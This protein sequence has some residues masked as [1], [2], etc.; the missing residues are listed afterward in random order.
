MKNKTHHVRPQKKKGV[1]LWERRIF[2]SWLRFTRRHRHS[3]RLPFF[4]FLLF[5]LDGFV[6]VVPS[7]LCMVACVTISPARWFLFAILFP[8]GAT[9][10]NA[11]TYLLGTLIPQ[12][13]LMSVIEFFHL[14]AFWEEAMKAVH[15]YGNWAGFVGAIM[16]LPTQMITAIIGLADVQVNA[17]AAIRELSIF[18]ALACV[19][20][21][22]FLKS[23]LVA[24][25]VVKGWSKI[26]VKIVESQRRSDIKPVSSGKDL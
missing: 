21:G 14:Q 17:H 7:T 15:Q 16:G 9:L 10:N 5:F 25:F 2:V 1:K 11:T 26:E 20:L 3:H 8:I 19:F 4:L 22:H 24:F 23:T 12:K 13:S 6:M 18:S